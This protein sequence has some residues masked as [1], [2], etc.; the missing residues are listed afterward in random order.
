MKFLGFFSINDLAT[1]YSVYFVP[2]HLQYLRKYGMR[3]TVHV[4]YKVKGVPVEGWEN[5][6]LAFEF[7]DSTLFLVN[8]SSHD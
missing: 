2:G 6:I 5:S 3:T 8:Y 4:N 1:C 7:T